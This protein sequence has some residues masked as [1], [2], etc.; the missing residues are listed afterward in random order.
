MA[1][2]TAV[3][4]GNSHFSQD[5]SNVISRATAIASLP[6]SQLNADKTILTAQAAA[7]TGL[8]GKFS[9]LQTSLQGVANAL[10]GSSFQADISDASKVKVTLGDGAMEGNYTIDVVDAGTY[11]TSMTSSGWVPGTGATRTYQLSL[12]GVNYGLSPA[13]NG[14]ASV[15]AAINSQYGDKVQA[16][17]VN[18]GS[19]TQA[20]Y[21]IS[22][23]SA[24]LGDLKPGLLVGALMPASLQGQQ[25]SGSNTLATSQ[26]A[27]TWDANPA[28]TY[29]LSLNGVNH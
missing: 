10:S 5:F 23:K 17:V 25:N 27:Q 9:A 19:G 11:A 15:A 20:D 8:D 2:T 7:L 3:F 26:T 13:D 28:L 1:T 14:A 6:I 24:Q 4:T 18:V 29:Q 22:L 21:R 16:T 12:G